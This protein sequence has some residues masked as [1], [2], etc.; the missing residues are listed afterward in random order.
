MTVLGN[1]SSGAFAV[2]PLR[3]PRRELLGYSGLLELGAA[4][5]ASNSRG[6]MLTLTPTEQDLADLAGTSRPESARSCA[7]LRVRE[8]SSVNTD[9]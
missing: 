8:Q 5:G 2:N 4:F 1:A 6:T 7:S 3:S 9:S